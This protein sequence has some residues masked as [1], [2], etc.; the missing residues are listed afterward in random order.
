MANE[1]RLLGQ[2]TPPE[3]DQLAALLTAWLARYE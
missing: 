3:A 1:H 2:L